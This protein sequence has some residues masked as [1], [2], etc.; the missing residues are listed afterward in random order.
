MNFILPMHLRSIGGEIAIPQQSMHGTHGTPSL[1]IALLL[2][3]H[4][5]RILWKSPKY[6]HVVSVRSP[7]SDPNCTSTLLVSPVLALLL[8]SAEKGVGLSVPSTRRPPCPDPEMLNV[9]DAT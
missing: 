6:F 8:T 3:V 2:L 5:L 9:A 4:T 7:F 1:Y